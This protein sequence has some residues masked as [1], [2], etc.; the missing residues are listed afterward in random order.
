MKK[1]QIKGLIVVTLF[2]SF[3]I[4]CHYRQ[5]HKTSLSTIEYQTDLRDF[6]IMFYNVENFFDVYDDSLTQDDDF[7]P[8]GALHWTTGRYEKKLNNIYKVI[9][10]LGGWQPPDIIALCEI[11]NYE[12]LDDLINNT[13]LLKYDYRIIHKNS[14]D[15]R[16]IDVAILYNNDRLKFIN[17]KFH[18]L[19]SESYSTTRDIL[20][21]K[22]LLGSDSCHFYVN[23]WPSRSGG[24]LETEKGRIAAARVLR[25]SIDSLFIINNN[26]KVLIMGDF[27]DEPHDISLNSIL[28]ANN[29]A[30][31]IKG[32]ELYN[33]TG[34]YSPYKRGTLKYQGMWNIFDQIIVS[35]AFLYPEPGTLKITDEGF[36][37]FDASFL[38][39]NDARYNGDKPF[40]TYTGYTYEGGFSDH[41]P[42]YADL[43][44]GSD[45][46][47]IK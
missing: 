3:V 46:V 33:L 22:A 38:L 27:N 39:T 17:S 30:D 19:K 36:R 45:Q 40:R 7:T 32:G 28:M 34:I 14:P 10:S 44:S 9:V 23:H 31:S 37:I 12:V 35:G 47:K 13:P 11:E 42:V 4:S 1:I 29:S 43:K 6:R 16:G 8:G 24:Q 15:Y 20:Y 21:F 18:S 41:L 5:L 26:S 2:I 25:K